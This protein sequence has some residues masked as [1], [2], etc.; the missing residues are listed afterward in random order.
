MLRMSDLEGHEGRG[1]EVE[2][3]DENDFEGRIQSLQNE[4]DA[5]TAKFAEEQVHHSVPLTRSRLLRHNTLINPS[6]S[7]ERGVG[8]ATSL[9]SSR[10]QEQTRKREELVS[11]LEEVEKES[12]AISKHMD[13]LQDSIKKLAA[14]RIIISYYSKN[15]VHSS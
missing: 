3:T 4:V 1:E 7:R 11:R 15:T 9:M 12:I 13:Q 6:D 14:V 5:L 8:N 2:A 10:L